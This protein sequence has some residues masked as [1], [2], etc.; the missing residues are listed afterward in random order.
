MKISVWLRILKV[1]CVLV[2]IGWFSSL[3]VANCY[4]TKIV[5]SMISAEYSKTFSGN[6]SYFVLA[7]P[8]ALIRVFKASNPNKELWS[9]KDSGYWS[10]QRQMYDGYYVSND[11]KSVIWL[12][13]NFSQDTL[14]NEVAIRVINNNGIKN[15]YSFDDL[16]IQ[17]INNRNEFAIG[18]IGWKT[19]RK[20]RVDFKDGKLILHVFPNHIKE[21]NF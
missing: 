9:V 8:G 17:F 21:I 11:G 2:L 7:Q 6:K 13:Q 14:G 19:W 4:A 20:P 15:S 16:K 5:P 10:W 1:S 18:P 12:F 3:V